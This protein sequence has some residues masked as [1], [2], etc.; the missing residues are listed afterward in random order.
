MLDL[1][2]E[3]ECIKCKWK[4]ELGFREDTS[5]EKK[6]TNKIVAKASLHGRE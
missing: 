4:N 6:E 3:N 2:Q 1:T 5:K